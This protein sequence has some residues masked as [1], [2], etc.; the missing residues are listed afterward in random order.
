MKR[1]IILEV[2][3]LYSDKIEAE[4]VESFDKTR[5]KLLVLNPGA[6][7]TLTINGTVVRKIP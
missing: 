3:S 7:A 6:T 4:I 2:D 1:I 5:L